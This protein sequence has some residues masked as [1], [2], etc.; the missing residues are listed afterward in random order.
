MIVKVN[1]DKNRRVS[2]SRNRI[3][4][5]GENNATTLLFNYPK[6]IEGGE[7]SFVAEVNGDSYILPISDERLSLPS[8]ILTSEEFL[9]QVVAKKD[10]SIIWK[11]SPFKFTLF[12]TINDS[13]ENSLDELKKQ[14]VIEAQKPLTILVNKLTEKFKNINTERSEDQ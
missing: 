9:A 1:I 4:T 11:T 6:E 3:G 7:Y 14:W 12:P 8:Y 2:C 5:V 10:G 13:G